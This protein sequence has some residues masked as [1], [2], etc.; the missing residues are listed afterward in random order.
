M[1]KLKAFS[2]CFIIPLIFVFGILWITPLSGGEDPMV[3]VRLLFLPLFVS[4]SL[5]LPAFAI[6]GTFRKYG[7]YGA[8]VSAIVIA[9][10]SRFFY[11]II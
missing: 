3:L 2:F 7:F 1:T 8:L 11:H 5:F 10:L 6:G 9:M 4:L